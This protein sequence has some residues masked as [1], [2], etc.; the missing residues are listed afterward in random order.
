MIKHENR[1]GVDVLTMA[2]GKGHAL[3]TLFLRTLREEI[4]RSASE[5]ASGLVLTGEGA[6]FCAGLDLLELLDLDRAGMQELVDALYEVCAALFGHPRPVVAALNGHAIAGGALLSLCCDQRIMAQGEAKWG[7]SESALGLSLPPFGLEAARYALPRPVLEKVLH[8]GSVY[9]AFKALDMGILDQL[10][11]P[12]A[13]VDTACASVRE[14]SVNPDAF[15]QNKSALH[16]PTLIAMEEARGRDGDW[17][18]LWFEPR[19]QELL[20]AARDQLVA[21]SGSGA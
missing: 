3:N 4:A 17:L 8:G 21:R 6:I 11:E 7:L 19:A 12:E 13:L 10:E 16:G 18:Q 1:D 14:W 2:R 5:P 15:S 20:R 9:P